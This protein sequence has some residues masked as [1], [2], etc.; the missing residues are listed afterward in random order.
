MFVWD[1]NRGT[2]I[3]RRRAAPTYAVREA[4]NQPVLLLINR[5]GNTMFLVVQPQ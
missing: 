4:D 2:R 1:C 5:G 3:M